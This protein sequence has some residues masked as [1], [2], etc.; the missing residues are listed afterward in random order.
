MTQGQNVS[1]YLLA[2]V[3][4]WNLCVSTHVVHRA[5]FLP[6]ICLLCTFNKVA[7]GYTQNREALLEINMDLSF[8][9]VSNSSIQVRNATEINQTVK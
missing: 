4:I 3:D 9:H 2:K 1:I 6:M 8:S 7:I 5:G